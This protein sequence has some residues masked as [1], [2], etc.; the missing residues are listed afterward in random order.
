MR[1]P[2]FLDLR[3]AVSHP[4]RAKGLGSHE[5]AITRQC[6]LLL[7]PA[8]CCRPC[9]S[10]YLHLRNTTAAPGPAKQSSCWPQFL[11]T[12]RAKVPRQVTGNIPRPRAAWTAPGLQEDHW[13][14]R[15]RAR[16]SGTRLTKPKCGT[17]TRT[18]W[19]PV[20][21]SPCPAALC[22][23]GPRGPAVSVPSRPLLRCCD[24]KPRG[25]IVPGPC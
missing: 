25:A 22:C 13:I 18:A 19:E 1:S 21:V 4:C 7:V 6:H 10:L 2:A 3:R 9:H 14:L 8:I 16:R 12:Y 15:S 5:H 24:Q 11:S 17:H 23:R 20:S